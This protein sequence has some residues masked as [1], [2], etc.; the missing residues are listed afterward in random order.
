[1]SSLVH[2]ATLLGLCSALEFKIIHVTK[3]LTNQHHPCFFSWQIFFQG[4]FLLG[5]GIFT[6]GF[7]LEGIFPGG[8]FTY[9]HRAH[10]LKMATS[11]GS[12]N[13]LCRKMFFSPSATRNLSS[14]L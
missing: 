7:L 3:M 14:L 1:M 6:G 11:K 13:T 2:A 4:D 12:L 5:R 10:D 9:I 8:I